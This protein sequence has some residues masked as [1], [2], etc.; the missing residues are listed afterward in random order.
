MTTDI[1]GR[2]AISWS[3]PGDRRKTG[4]KLDHSAAA[5][6]GIRR[7]IFVRRKSAEKIAAHRICRYI[8][9]AEYPPEENGVP[10]ICSS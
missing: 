7:R 8:L 9:F 10:K 1:S 3:T 4:R 2:S 5:I 6:H